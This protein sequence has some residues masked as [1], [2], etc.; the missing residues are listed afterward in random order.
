MVLGAISVGWMYFADQVPD[1]HE[2]SE[3]VCGLASE[4]AQCE[5]G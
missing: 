1:R 4:F 2:L 5:P 3:I